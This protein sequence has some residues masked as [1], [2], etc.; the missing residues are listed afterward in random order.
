MAAF[1]GSYRYTIDHKGRVNIPAKLRK[2]TASTSHDLYVI[3]RGLEGCLFIYPAEEWE[4]VEEKL[5][6]LS[7]TQ[8]SHRLF[9][10]YLLSNACDSQLDRQGRITIPQNLLEFARIKKEVLIIGLLERIEI[11]DP[12][13]HQEYL[14][15]AGKTY[16]EIAE[17]IYFKE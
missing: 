8:K 4:T 3:T 1:K 9:A 12:E 7:F 2:S 14:N 16:E 10:R 5:R 15:S 13:V 11:W 17:E 6:N